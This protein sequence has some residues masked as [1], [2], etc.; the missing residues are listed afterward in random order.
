MKKIVIGLTLVFCGI[1]LGFALTLT[2]LS[3]G[4]QINVPKIQFETWTEHYDLEL[5]VAQDSKNPV[6]GYEAVAS[7]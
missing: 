1:V 2:A 3:N 7:K 6:T 5:N 4:V